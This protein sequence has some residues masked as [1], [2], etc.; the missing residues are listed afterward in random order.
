[1]SGDNVNIAIG[2][3]N[4]QVIN[5]Y[6]ART[7]GTAV[8]IRDSDLMAVCSHLHRLQEAARASRSPDTRQLE[9][10]LSALGEQ[11]VTRKRVDRASASR[12]LELLKPGLE[13]T[14]PVADAIDA[15]SAL[16]GG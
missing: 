5:V 13:L 4:R 6:A 3:G 16:F 11:V 7:G 15:L 8:E 1:M 10:D 14:R 2:D 12:L 9:R